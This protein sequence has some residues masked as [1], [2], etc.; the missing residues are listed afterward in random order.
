MAQGDDYNQRNGRKIKAQ[1]IFLNG[2]VKI[3][4]SASETTM[5][6]IIFWD[7]DSDGETA[8]ASEL[9]QDGGDLQSPLNYANAGSR[10]KVIYDRNFSLSSNG[11]QIKNVYCYRRL[12]H[13][14]TY[15]GTGSTS[16]N[17]GTGT[18]FML[19][20]SNEP[21]NTPTFNYWARFRYTDN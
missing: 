17:N 16:G 14:I 1:S 3:N 19:L 13:H 8:T 18:L 20:M 10:F 21:T 5:R 4:S 9:L 11:P 15:L 6:V 12:Y 2:Q 7:K